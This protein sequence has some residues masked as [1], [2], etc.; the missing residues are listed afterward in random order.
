MRTQQSYPE[1]AAI[2]QHIR[3]AHIERVIPIAEGISSFLVD[4]WKEIKGPPRP[5]A[6]IINGR[7]P[8][9]GI[10]GRGRSALIQ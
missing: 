2:E 6:V 7:Y 8:F 9:A 3:N 5:A 10:E 1:Y 4:L